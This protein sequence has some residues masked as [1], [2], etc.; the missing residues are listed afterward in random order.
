MRPAHTARP[1][2]SGQPARE[3]ER[4]DLVARILTFVAERRLTSGER[5]PSERE[6]A[7][8]FDVGRNA[9]REAIAV[10]ETVR[11]VERRPNSGIYLRSFD[12]DGSLDAL[13][14]RADLG[15]P[16]DA[17]EVAELI[18]LRRILEVQG[19]ELA[20]QRRQAEDLARIDA[21]LAAGRA[22][23][24]A[25]GNFAERDAEFHLA[26]A[27]ATRNRVLL[28]VVNSFYILSRTRRRHYFA[29]GR[30]APE[31][32]RQHEAMA[33]AIRA[34]DGPGAA[35]LMRAH[36]QSAEAY[37]HELLQRRPQ[38]GEAAS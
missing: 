28:R 8:R 35:A 17:G 12:R 14:L 38:E 30:R 27:E 37:W 3:D 19:T 16:L 26:V 11:M 36:L 32:Q 2:F 13:V 23:I 9:I 5:L 24:A 18:E 20:G 6:L 4:S 7:E 31:A 1:A 10:L 29:D 15:V 21:M 33:A 22:T 34:H 25:G